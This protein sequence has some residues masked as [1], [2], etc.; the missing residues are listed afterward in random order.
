QEAALLDAFKGNGALFQAS[1]KK[2]APQVLRKLEKMGLLKQ[3]PNWTIW[4][5][6]D[7]G[8]EAIKDIY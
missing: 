5:I 2:H 7:A 3:Q 1:T 8:R 4:K 6:T